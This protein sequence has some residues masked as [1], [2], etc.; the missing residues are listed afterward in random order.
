MA[1]LLAS[2]GAA[3]QAPS[4]RAEEPTIHLR[5]IT[6]Y[7]SSSGETDSRPLI[8]ACGPI[9]SGTIAVSR[10]LFYSHGRRRCGDKATITTAR[11][12]R[13]KGVIWDTM[14][15]RWRKAADIFVR[16]RSTALKFGVQR[17]AI[18]IRSARNGQN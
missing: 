17:G 18:E 12:E 13:I 5:R 15:V 1:L 8:A 9:R 2:Y 3:V 10:D 14:A 6:A 11:G 4:T 16:S 7:T